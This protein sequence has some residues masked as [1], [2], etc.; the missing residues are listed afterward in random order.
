MSDTCT[1]N[2]ALGLSSDP[3][4]A[5][6]EVYMRLAESD[7]LHIIFSHTPCPKQ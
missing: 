7:S 1:W 5:T 6:I 4:S 2:E 3:Y